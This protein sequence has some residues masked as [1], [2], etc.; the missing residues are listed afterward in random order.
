MTENISII[1]KLFIIF[2]IFSLL[3]VFSI[4][5]EEKAS[6]IQSVTLEDFELDQNGKQKRLW[7]AVPER[8]GRENNSDTGKSLQ[9]VAW[10]E[11]WPEAYFGREGKYDDGNEVK[12]YKT[13]LGV[14]LEFNRRGYNKVE[15]YPVE[16]KDGKIIGNPIIFKGRVK[17]ID[18]WIWGS[19][20]NYDMEMVLMDYKGIYH[21]LPVG[22][23]KHI[24]WKNFI[25]TIPNYIPQTS[26]YNP[27]SLKFSL[28]KLEIWTA[29]DERVTGAYVY[30]D[31]IK[32]LTDLMETQYDGYNL[33]NDNTVKNLWE[34]APKAPEKTQTTTK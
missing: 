19:N 25:V 17:Q 6:N 10:V 8:F 9:E 28:V 33:G 15:L 30:I 16:E 5:P 24:G 32:Y 34:K 3:N 12:N 4:F 27:N 7:I 21:R 23:L 22:N 13:S 11:A 31:H 2:V 14:K 1:K 26:S 18:L 20:Y 29:P